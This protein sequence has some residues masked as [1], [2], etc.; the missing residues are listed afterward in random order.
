MEMIYGPTFANTGNL[1]F[2]L[3]IAS[4]ATSLSMIADNGVMAVNRPDVSFYAE[5]ANGVVTIVLGIVLISSL[6]LPGSAIAIF[7]GQLVGAAILIFSVIRLT[8]KELLP[9]ST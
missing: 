7:S 5:F 4:L 9:R 1:T 3:S 8:N 6:G 2:L